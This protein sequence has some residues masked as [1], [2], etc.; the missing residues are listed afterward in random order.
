MIMRPAKALL[1]LAAFALLA[2]CEGG[3][4]G[5]GGTAPPPNDQPVASFTATPASGL[6]PLTVQFDASASTDAGGSISTYKWNFGDSTPVGSG[7]TTVHAFQAAGTYTVTLTVTDNLGATGSTTRQVTV[8]APP[9][10]PIK[11]TLRVPK[12]GGLVS[13]NVSVVVSVDSTYE[14][15]SVTA[16]LAGNQVSLTYSAEAYQCTMGMSC[17][18]FVGTLSLAGQPTGSFTLKIRAT[19]ARGNVDEVSAS[20]IHDNPPLL[21][22]TEPVDL[23]VAL[24]TVP[25]DASCADDLPECVVELLV[26]DGLQR[27]APLTLSGQL[28]LSAWEGEVVDVT[29]RARDSARQETSLN[30]TVFVEDSA[31]LTVVTELPGLVLDADDGRLL[32]VEHADAGD[33]LAIYDRVSG[34]TENVVMPDGRKVREDSAYLTPSGAIFV[35]QAS[36]DSVLTSR[37]YLWHSGSLTD[38]AY[39]ISAASLS[40]SGGYA[41]WNE[42][43]NLYRLNTATGASALVTSDAGNWQNS[44]AADGTVVFWNTSYQI[45]RDRLGQQTALTNDP[46]QWHVYP[47]TDGDKVLYRRQDPCCANQLF[48]IVLVEGLDLIPLSAKRGAEPWPGRDYQ[49][50]SGWAAYTDT[51][52]LGQLHVFTRSPQGV[53]TRHT[54]LGTSSRLDH[55]AGNGEVMIFNGERRYFSRGPALIAV[56]ST[57]GHGYWLNGAWY[58]AIG[59]VFLSVNTSD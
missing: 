3:G 19:D 55:L 21:T 9:P 25:F 46:S 54:D 42:G 1:L 51:G 48:D 10:P 36:S 12:A 8:S 22:V 14:V 24:P 56:S 31:R 47:R 18:G 7:V 26:N 5:D 53:I 38:L 52:N 34:L 41:V 15:S 2:A 13:D 32:F 23:S 43:T 50:D 28:D 45:V 39:P 37:V 11:V 44:V 6:A 16:S 27:S 35:T 20:V 29:L 33:K 17:P 4:G 40:V 59:R 58:V 30:R 57:A 49:I